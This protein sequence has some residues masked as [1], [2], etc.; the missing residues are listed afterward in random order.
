[1]HNSPAPLAA[2]GIALAGLALGCDV[3]AGPS[4]GLQTDP[5]AAYANL[6][7]AVNE[8]RAYPR[9]CG[10]Q[11]FGAAAPVAWNDRLELA[12]E[13][14]TLDMSSH[15]VLAHVGSD[16]STVGDRVSNAGYDWRRVGENLA[17]AQRSAPEVV[18]LWLASPGHCANVMHPSY[19][20][21]GVAE[22]GG[23]WTQVMGRP[24]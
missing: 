21:M 24:G 11:P 23:Y 5:P 4:A 3:M 19:V 10:D 2:L 14:H 20:E 7:V 9:M 8:A 22:R 13:R 12:A 1:M 6:M 18:A 17:H 16:G 15:G